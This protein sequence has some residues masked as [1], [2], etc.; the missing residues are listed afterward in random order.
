MALL[1]FLP[2]TP[3]VNGTVVLLATGL[4]WIGSG[5]LETSAE[6]L[7]AH[8]GLPAVV[9][10]SI[11]VAIGSSFPEL[12]SVVVAALSGVF[13][14]GV[15]AVVGSAIF[16][17]LVIP[18][19]SGL[20]AAD[21]L[22]TNRTLV[23]KE[24]QFYMI[25]VSALIITFAFAVIYVPVPDAPPLVGRITRPLAVVPLLLY[26][27]YLFIQWQDVSDHGDEGVVDASIRRQWLTLGAG[28]ALILVAVEQLVGSVESLSST[29]GIPELLAGVTIVA[30]A[31]SLPDL[32]VSVRSARNDNSVTSLANVLG[33][34]TF[35]LLVA[36]PIGVLI[37][38]SVTIDFATAVPMFAVLTLATVVLFA[39]IRT[40]LR[41]S[42]A[43][44]YGLLVCYLLFVAWLITEVLGITAVLR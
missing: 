32:L 27:L 42:K 38:G 26:G 24:A 2:N 3:L 19:L 37:A 36:I 15:G 31:T 28:L 9:Q 40:D 7:S 33:S 10:G 41:L 43:E 16:N 22:E 17:I 20:A 4:I 18:A 34:N 14:I 12:S 29:F 6:R 8:Y 25:A 23:Y 13:D 44:S 35:D 5:W 1:G 30:A 39:M 21:T 11:V